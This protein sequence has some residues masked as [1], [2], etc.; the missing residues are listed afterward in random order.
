VDRQCL[1][2]LWPTDPEDDKRGI[3]QRKGCLLKDS[4]RWI[5]DNAYFRRWRDDQQSRLLWIKGDP[6]KGK[7]ML[8]C[9]IINELKMSTAETSVVF[10]FCQGTDSRFN[11]AKAVLR[12]LIYLLVNQQLSLIQHL[13]KNYEHEEKELFDGVNA[14][15]ALSRIFTNILQDPSLKR[16]YLIIDALDEC[17]TGLLQLLN[18][19][20]QES[21]ASPH[22][23]WIVS[24]RYNTNVEQRLRLDESRA[25]L[26]LELKENAERVS[27]AV[28][29][30]I[31]HCVSDLAVIQQYDQYDK[32][33]QENVRNKMR[34][35]ANGTFLWVSLVTKELQE[36]MSWNVLQVIDEVP[37]ELIGVY[38]RMVQQIQRLQRGDS[39]RCR[40]VLSTVTA[41]YRP[42]RLQEVG[43]LS[44]LPGDVAAKKGIVEQIVNMCG[45]FFTI[46]NEKVYIIHQSANDFLFGDAFNTI[47]PSGTG[48]VHRT[49]F[50]TSVQIMSRTL[51][52]DI[53]GLCAPG[54]P[55]DLVEQPDS[56][57]LAA[58]DYSC[59]YWVD[60][61]CDWDSSKSAKHT[62]DLQDGGAVDKFLK[63]KY[64]HWLEGLSL[65]RSISEGVLS[66]AKLE[67]LLQVSFK[68]VVLF[69][70][71]GSVL[72][73]L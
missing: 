63:Q 39:E 55:I 72:T 6:G 60:H 36:V 61:L 25:R 56:N 73:S 37:S 7:T 3:E 29:A 71:L 51:R 16:T 18:L 53:Y 13:R 19:I 44:G 27:D 1:K 10:F 64:L 32:D 40:L 20:V 24:S 21:S 48:D 65:R 45:S 46:R 26:S 8:L 5:L 28:D 43:I 17:Q 42:L 4:Y 52:R 22:I 57:P 62:D 49:M 33:L 38:H 11:N 35:K 15:V 59:V 41:A 58:A 12:G 2:D 30:Y 31:D 67:G 23:K 14:W 69:Y 50:S 9:G 68:P 66:M 34:R 54:F 70:Y 47:F